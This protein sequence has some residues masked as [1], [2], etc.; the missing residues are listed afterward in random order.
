M[1]VFADFSLRYHLL[2]IR[3]C[4]HLIVTTML[5]MVLYKISFETVLCTSLTNL[6][7]ADHDD[8]NVSC[9][10]TGPLI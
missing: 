9:I 1:H 7:W 6:D 4:E 5:L 2:H 8:E 10:P 3:L